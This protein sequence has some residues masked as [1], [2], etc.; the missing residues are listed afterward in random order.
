MQSRTVIKRHRP[1]FWSYIRQTGR[2]SFTFSEF[3]EGLVSLGLLILS[4]VLGI[5]TTLTVH[6]INDILEPWSFR[7]AIGLVVFLIV[8]FLIITPYR[9][10][11]EAAWVANVEKGLDGLWDL[12]DKGVDLLNAHA[13]L[14]KGDLEVEWVENWIKDEQF[15]RTELDKALTAFAPAEARRLKNIVTFTL[16]L[17][18]LNEKHIFHRNILSERLER[19]GKV[20]ERHHPA[21]LPE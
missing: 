9:M 8:Q 20:L 19:L 15:W 1:S 13:G 7:V 2:K 17:N 4:A 10:W 5:I 12:H 14:Q 6:E 16:Q 3:A 11:R 18:G 21:L